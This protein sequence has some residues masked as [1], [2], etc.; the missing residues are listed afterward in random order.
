MSVTSQYI[1]ISNYA[2]VEY[3]YSDEIITT[4]QARCIRLQNKY[5]NTYQ[6]L[7]GA[8]A[9]QRTGNILDKSASK[10]GSMQSQLWSFHDIDVPVPT[11]QTDPNY[12]L[13]DVT[14]SLL[15]NQRYD[16]I[17]VHLLAG[18]TFP[19]LD[20]FILEVLFNEWTATG[21]NSRPFTAAANVYLKNEPNVTF[22]TDP[23]FVGDRYYDR[24]VQ[25]KVPSLY[26]VNQDYWTS[27]AATNTIGYQY[28]FNGVGFLQN[29]QISLNL[30]EINETETVNGNPFLRTGTAYNASINQQ[31]EFSFVGAVVKENAEYDYIE[32]YPTYQGGFIEDYINLLNETGQWVVINQLSI[33]E[34]VG[35]SFIKTSD[36]TML[37]EENFDQP[38]VFRPIIRN[39]PVV[40]AYT[41][42]YVMRLLNKVNNQEII[43][44]S[45]FTSTDVK[46]YGLQLEKINAL[47]GF[48][49]I[50]VYN[51]I[52]KNDEVSGVGVSFGAPRFITQ[53]NYINNYFD[54]NYISVDSTTDI[55]AEVGQKVYPQGQNVFFINPF[56]NFVKFKIFTK[57]KDKKQDVTMDLASTGMNIKLSFVFD[58]KSQIFIEPTQD[59]EAANPGAG[60]ILFKI[61][62][63]TSIKLLA[64]SAKNY[65]LVNK[66]TEGDD[67][68]IYS[69]F[70]EDV[71]LR[72]SST[73]VENQQEKIIAQYEEKIASLEK[74]VSTQQSTT[75]TPNGKSVVESV[76]SSGNIT[77]TTSSVSTAEDGTTI[78]KTS[79]A[80]SNPAEEFTRQEIEKA[81][82]E[83]QQQTLILQ[84]QMAALQR[85]I[86]EAAQKN[87][88]QDRAISML[89]VPEVPGATQAPPTA[90]WNSVPPNV[91][92]PSGEQTISLQDIKDDNTQGDVVGFN[93][94]GS[95]IYAQNPQ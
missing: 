6:F 29:S 17:K 72:N 55:S 16:T 95:P 71:N 78:I 33:L 22:A 73:I 75:V 20:G 84:S 47:E 93:P 38:G 79:S 13:E 67:V 42:E 23:I 15:S 83:A 62:S 4:S 41:I 31:D 32:Y 10:N 34:Q 48:R 37:Q 27:P 44:R 5:T 50:K 28:S 81:K 14:S 94:D 56:D 53:Y 3:I 30:Y 21:T 2:L 49:P 51:K 54:V 86:I 64:Q 77:T 74:Q 63:Q 52:V 89:N 80:S 9:Y 57:S 70:Y 25:I 76:D 18:Y 36:N 43:R 60:E 11:I 40:Y 35:T 90:S 46:K 19:G 45:T 88:D 69:G 61:E 26:R 87:V 66:S 68:L 24:Y 65:Y 1:Q 85:A 39:A 7:N 8:Q 91:Q 59:M 58:D 82:I 12:V 92:N